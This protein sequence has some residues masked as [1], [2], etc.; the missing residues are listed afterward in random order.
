MI[1]KKKNRFKYTGG[2]VDQKNNRV[3]NAKRV[4]GIKSFRVHERKNDF[5]ST[6]EISIEKTRETNRKEIHSRGKRADIVR[7]ETVTH[8]KLW[9]LPRTRHNQ[10]TDRANFL[11]F[12]FIKRSIAELAPDRILSLIVNLT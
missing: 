1:V 2:Q 8:P 5:Y 12:V 6:L 10:Q 11:F 3:N 7:S 9:P 4:F